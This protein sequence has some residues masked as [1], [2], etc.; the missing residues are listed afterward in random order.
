MFNRATAAGLKST[1]LQVD[2]S[3]WRFNLART[4]KPVQ[5]FLRLNLEPAA[6]PLPKTFFV[7]TAPLENSFPHAVKPPAHK[8]YG[9][10]GSHSCMPQ[11]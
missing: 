2:W 1:V 9:F 3:W 6:Q 11:P 5:P 8:P 4:G 7:N 10:S